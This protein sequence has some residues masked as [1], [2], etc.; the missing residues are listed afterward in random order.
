[1]GRLSHLHKP[2]LVDEG[3]LSHFKSKSI[4]NDFVV[5]KG[6]PANNHTIPSCA[7][8]SL[9]LKFLHIAKYKYNSFNKK[10]TDGFQTFFF[11]NKRLLVL[12]LFYGNLQ[13][14]FFPPTKPVN[15][16]IQN[17]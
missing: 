7:L 14:M 15:L 12:V 6:R 16:L 17:E 2:E 9:K 4:N 1:M 13:V 3:T 5:L 8:G 11:L 10:L